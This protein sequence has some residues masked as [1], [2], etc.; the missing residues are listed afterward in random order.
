MVKWA[1]VLEVTWNWFIFRVVWHICLRECSS[2]RINMIKYAAK[3]FAF[4]LLY[5]KASWSPPTCGPRNPAAITSENLGPDAAPTRSDPSTGPRSLPRRTLCETAP[6]GRGLLSP[7]MLRR[8]PLSAGPADRARPSPALRQHW[9]DRRRR[10]AT[11][12]RDGPPAAPASVPTT[13]RRG[14]AETPRRVA[15]KLREIG[16]AK[17]GAP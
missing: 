10:R 9:A 16:A 14:G 11:Q 12:S 17:A 13:P 8:R 15:I 7:E 3:T 4:R 2:K 6:A 5:S 1:R